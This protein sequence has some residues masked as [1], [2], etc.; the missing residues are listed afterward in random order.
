MK[1]CLIVIAFLS[2]LCLGYIAITHGQDTDTAALKK[3]WRDAEAKIKEAND[4]MN[5][6]ELEFN[7]YITEHN[8]ITGNALSPALTIW[9]PIDLAKSVVI[10]DAP[11]NRLFFLEAAI[12]ATIIYFDDLNK[13]LKERVS[14]RDIALTNY[15]SATGQ[16]ETAI[17]SAK[18]RTLPECRLPCNNK[19]GVIFSS[20]DVGYDGLSNAAASKHKTICGE[21]SNVGGCGVEHWTCDGNKKEFEK[22]QVLYC[23]KEIR[24][25]LKGSEDNPAGFG[26]R[27]KVLGICGEAYR[28]CDKP[29]KKVFHEYYT[30]VSS[31]YRSGTGYYYTEYY[32]YSPTKHGANVFHSPKTIPLTVSIYGPNGV[33]LAAD[34][35][36]KSP[37]CD[38]CIDGSR[39]CPDARKNHPKTNPDSPASFKLKNGAARGSIVLTWTK[40]K[41]DGNADITDYQYK[42][43][44]RTGGYGS[45]YTS[46]SD[47]RSAGTDRYELIT[48]LHRRAR[49]RIAMRSKNSANMYS[50]SWSV[51]YINVK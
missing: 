17:H 23:T 32:T 38:S 45:S 31:G 51:K 26:A 1:K 42:I 11:Q 19:C 8:T 2:T 39:Y 9:S 7:G 30:S 3:A 6:L 33:G 16:Q 18:Y 48:G 37:G 43:A 4:R 22:H 14:A 24:F 40:T 35:L 50:T 27:K 20:N 13:I 10:N 25:W 49:Y 47:W 15:N 12:Y 44:Y 29:A 36:D 21:G 5:Q 28:E 41:F 46:W 34:A